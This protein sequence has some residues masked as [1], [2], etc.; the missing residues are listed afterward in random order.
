[1]SEVSNAD[2][3]SQVLA[4]IVKIN[5]LVA[6]GQYR[7]AGEESNSLGA[8]VDPLPA[9]SD[10]RAAYL[11]AAGIVAY[12]L[13]QYE[14]S[15]SK[16]EGS[17]SIR[18]TN[19]DA[20]HL[21]EVLRDLG[22][23]LRAGGD[24]KRA[25][26]VY[27]EAQEILTREF[28]DG[29]TR[30]ADLL[31]NLSVL[32]FG[33]SRLVESEAACRRSLEL[34]RNLL[35]PGHHMVGQCLSNLAQIL[36]Q[37]GRLAEAEVACRQGLEVREKALPPDHPDVGASLNNLAVILY[38]KGEYEQAEDAQRRVLEID[39]K[40]WGS[41]SLDVAID[42]QNLAE[43]EYRQ[44]KFASALQLQQQVLSIR[45]AKLSP[46]HP[47]LALVLGNLANLFDEIGRL[48]EAEGAYDEA[49][50][51]ERKIADGGVSI[52]LATSL[53]NFGDMV[54]RKGDFA[55]ARSVFE[56]ALDG[57]PQS[58]HNSRLHTSILNNLADI[59]QRSGDDAGAEDLFDK[60][61]AIRR[62]TLPADHPDLTHSLSRLADI[63]AQTAGLSVALEL[64]REAVASVKQRLSSSS[65]DAPSVTAS[66]ARMA[67][68]TLVTH[69]G[70][71]IRAEDSGPAVLDDFL[72]AAQMA[73]ATDTSIALGRMAEQHAF[74]M[75]GI[76]GEIARLRALARE[77]HSLEAA[78]SEAAS[79]SPAGDTA[80]LVDQLRRQLKAIVKER[81]EIQRSIPAAVQRV[82]GFEPVSLNE[83]RKVIDADEAVLILVTGER[84]GAAAVV[85]QLA[86]SLA[87]IPLSRD[88]FAEL[89]G[90]VRAT[91]DL[92]KGQ[93]ALAPF[94]VESART[95]AGTLLLPFANL[96]R[97]VKHLV[98]VLDEPAASL[99]I[100]ILPNVLPEPADAADHASGAWLVD[101]MA[102]TSA[103][104]SSSLHSIRTRAG[105]SKGLEP[106]VGIGAPEVRHL[107]LG[108]L[109]RAKEQLDV[110]REALGGKSMA[111]YTGSSATKTGIANMNLGSAR[112][113]AFATHGL[114]AEEAKRT[115]GPAEPALVLSGSPPDCFFAASEIAKLELDADWVVLS[116]CN[117]AAAAGVGAEGLS[118]IARAFFEAGART[119]L[120]SHWAVSELS[121]TRLLRYV[122]DQT[123]A[124][125]RLPRAE[126]LRRAMR[127]VRDS[128]LPAHAHPAYWGAFALVGEGWRS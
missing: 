95:L 39:L 105:R 30:T 98:C 81:N 83:F 117:T 100:A 44:R 45:R 127:S 118:G 75:A 78:L 35:G 110:I 57:L 51:I 33:Q 93:K 52:G 11:Q 41:G 85:T 1:M 21:A 86:A 56:Q 15:I 59:R 2:A 102:L 18:R 61:V 24:S 77:E 71:L 49:I 72:F 79:Q 99:P 69:L 122:F 70:L 54:R 103:P 3:S 106:F 89:V 47:D 68:E 113:V 128:S 12:H 76:G 32:Y 66:E 90:K 7:A 97:D 50:A 17:A 112:V 124:V 64:S 36:V 84:S 10:V 16:L 38:E 23:S 126:R 62:A 37:Q 114:M 26:G 9:V 20:V 121:T 19:E 109:P 46:D 8:L 5:S 82:Y 48:N 116:A 42:L 43:M 25:E 104:S 80:D 31:S 14:D 40:V 58:A 94:D 53:N 115:G 96:L 120:V 13:H 74:A 108:A 88:S 107:S 27:R 101:R 67:R 111:V 60:V 22:A 4:A 29:D 125:R 28:P 6:Q 55:A 34:R 87:Q 123:E 65:I 73:S 63:K 91:I 92:S 119:L